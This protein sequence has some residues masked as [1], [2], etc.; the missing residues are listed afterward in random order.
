M[1][2]DGLFPKRSYSEVAKDASVID[3]NGMDV[4]KDAEKKMTCNVLS[5]FDDVSIRLSE[6][7]K[8]S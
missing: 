2:F 5:Q 8:H 1:A 3:K 4:S 6:I 7:H